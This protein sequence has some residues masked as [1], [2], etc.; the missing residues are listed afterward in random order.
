MTSCNQY[1]IYHKLLQSDSKMSE[2]SDGEDTD[3]YRGNIK[4]VGDKVYGQTDS[5]L[6]RDKMGIEIDGGVYKLCGNVYKSGGHELH[7]V[8]GMLFEECED[9]NNDIFREVVEWTDGKYYKQWKYGWLKILERD[10]CKL[11][12]KNTEFK[13]KRDELI[14]ELDEV[15]S[16]SKELQKIFI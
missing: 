10:K 11:K 5:K 1:P 9:S 6:D 13:I 12:R 14:I 4:F 16:I 2:Q 15:I 3:S 7:W 8:K